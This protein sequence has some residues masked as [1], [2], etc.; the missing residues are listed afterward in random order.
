MFNVTYRKADRSGP[1]GNC[2]EVGGNWQ[3]PARS[4]GG[5]NC[6]EVREPEHGV[7]LFRDT[8]FADRRLGDSPELVMDLGE[9]LAF[10]ASARDGQFDPVD[11]HGGKYEL[12]ADGT[13]VD[14][15]GQPVPMRTI[16]DV[17]L[18][19]GADRGFVVV[20]A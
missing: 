4:N 11:A 20:G 9:L 8:K 15:T 13:V 12:R 5:D 6:L 17:E 2:L 10:L 7:F 19:A 18:L 3:T 16:T 1:Q 14:S